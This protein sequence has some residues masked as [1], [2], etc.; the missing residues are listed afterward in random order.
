MTKF[1]FKKLSLD[2][3]PDN[4]ISFIEKAIP[5]IDLILKQYLYEYFLRYKQHLYFSSTVIINNINRKKLSH[6][7]PLP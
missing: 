4:Y 6:D 3:V 7:F 1:F 2:Y 5:D